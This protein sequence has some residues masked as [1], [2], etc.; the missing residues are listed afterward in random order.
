[1]LPSAPPLS[2]PPRPSS[3]PTTRR[4]AVLDPDARGSRAY[5]PRRRRLRD[6]AFRLFCIGVAAVS[7]LVLLVLLVSICWGGIEHVTWS[8][9]T[10]P[11]DE[12]NWNAAG[13]WPALVGTIW[14]CSVCA[15]VALLLGVATAIYLEEFK[16][17]QNWLRRMQGFIQLN[18]A[19]LAGV[20][21]VVYGILGLTIFVQ[22]FNLLGTPRDPIF[23]F[24]V[25]WFSQYKVTQIQEP[26]GG[27]EVDP[28]AALMGEFSGDKALSTIADSWVLAIPGG[29]QAAARD[30]QLRDGMSIYL[31][32]IEQVNDVKRDKLG[33]KVLGE[34]GTPVIVVREK[35]TDFKEVKLNLIGPD[36]PYP[37]DAEL[38]H[39]TLRGTEVNGPLA[40]PSWYYFQIPF[41][42][43]V[44]AGGLTL[45]LVILP[46]VVIAGQ[47]ALRG[48]P[49]SLREGALGMGCTRWQVVKRV[50]L[51]A[52]VPGI[53]TGSILAMSRAVGEAAPLVIITGITFAT[54][55]PSNLMDSFTA[56]PLQVFNWSKEAQPEPREI[57]AGG[58][59][60]LLAVLLMFNA[61]AVLIRYK[62]QKPL[63]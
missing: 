28:M 61:V 56:L 63:S 51:P 54:F 16:P 53:M 47:E 1:M 30:P 40:V 46:V 33:Q 44:L 59:V 13:V 17:R 5:S 9:L 32:V 29:T 42:R 57:A 27:G 19:N 36:D 6:E 38:R 23:S 21:S 18:I 35:L 50:T 14:I 26:E 31:P 43:S 20:P 45:A 62:L 10:N 48:V 2:A 4:P 24:G 60:V 11:P 7:L 34:D 58:I 12:S 8:F 49:N 41:G 22:M 15:I 3:S 55:A 39:R 37:D 25:D 52:A